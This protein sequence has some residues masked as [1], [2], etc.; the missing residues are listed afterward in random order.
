VTGVLAD[1]LAARRLVE[2]RLGRPPQDM[3]EAAVAL[4]AWAGVPAQGALDAGRRLMR[5]APQERSPSRAALPARRAAR[6]AIV[7]AVTFLMTVIA[8]ACWAAPLAAAAG[9]DVVGRG[10]MLALPVTLGLQWGLSCRYF[11]REHGR[12]QLARRRGVIAP[13]AVVLVAVAWSALGEAGLLAGLLTVTWVAGTVLVRCGWAGAYA[14]GIALTTVLMLAGLSPVELLGA[15]AA[16]TLLASSAALRPQ[17]PALHGARPR[18]S[19]VGAAAGIGAGTG[20]LLVGDPSVSWT[21]GALPAI[22]L[23]PSAIAG[24]WA[25]YRLRDVADAIVRATAGVEVGMRPPTG[26]RSAPLRLF[27]SALCEFVLLAAGLSALLLLPDGMAEPSTEAGLLAGFGLLALATLLAGVLE[28]LGRSGAVVAVLALAAAAEAYVRW[29]DAAPY[30]GAGLVA[31]GVVA[32]ACL[33]P[34]V[35]VVLGR[36][37]STLATALW[38]T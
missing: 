18:W 23:L 22:E 14:A 17:G 32:T 37:A 5:E 1:P 28:S 15:A 24:F 7:E 31:A 10:V 2:A 6:G 3:L 11:V 25:S 33:L 29:S 16:A 12:D 9:A 26:L 30:P 19:R 21:E 13:G 4:E 27:A 8:I 35:L 36:P 20:L 34:V 38:I